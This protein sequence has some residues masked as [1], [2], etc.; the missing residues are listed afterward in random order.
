[1]ASVAFDR[2]G[3]GCEKQKLLRGHGLCEWKK[4]RLKETKND[5]GTWPSCKKDGVMLAAAAG[6]HLRQH[7]EQGEAKSS[8]L[9]SPT[10]DDR[11]QEKGEIWGQ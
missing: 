3:C 2:P 11:G 5:Y 4:E 10:A 6:G 8:F 7:R 1:M 9:Q